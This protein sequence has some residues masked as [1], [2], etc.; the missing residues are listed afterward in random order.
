MEKIFFDP[1]FSLEPDFRLW[2]E[3]TIINRELTTQFNKDKF[4]NWSEFFEIG[5]KNREYWRQLKEPQYHHAASLLK[6]VIDMPEGEPITLVALLDQA[7]S[8][9][10]EQRAF[11]PDHVD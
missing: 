7:Q 11:I 4:L 9:G 6:V 3:G 1:Q 5:R 2:H 10:A 8:E